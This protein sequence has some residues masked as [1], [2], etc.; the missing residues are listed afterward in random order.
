[1][2]F[3]AIKLA[4]SRHRVALR[5]LETEVTLR[6]CKLGCVCSTIQAFFFL[7]CL[8][9]LWVQIH[10]SDVTVTT[11]ALKGPKRHC[12]TVNALLHPWVAGSVSDLLWRSLSLESRKK[13]I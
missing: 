2:A 3:A 5:D 1:V 13:P 10:I 6:A 8:K 9:L 4:H 11:I 7:E 12:Q